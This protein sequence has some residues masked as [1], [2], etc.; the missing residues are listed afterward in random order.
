[1]SGV[2]SAYILLLPLAANLLAGGGKCT[3]SNI[4][5]YFVLSS[6][7]VACWYQIMH[8]TLAIFQPVMGRSGMKVCVSFL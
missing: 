3:P 7:P 1:M 5:F 6:F 2:M 4:A 8:T